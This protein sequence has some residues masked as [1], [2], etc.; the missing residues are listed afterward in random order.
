MRVPP[1]SQLVFDQVLS[2]GAVATS[3]FVPS[4]PK[5]NDWLGR[6]NDLRL[7]VVVSRA[8]I[9]GSVT[10]KVEETA[11]EEGPWWPRLTAINGA[12][13]SDT[14]E[15]VLVNSDREAVVFRPCL[16]YR[17][18]LVQI[19]GEAPVSARVRIWATGRNGYRQFN[20]LLLSERV[21]GTAPIYALHE[22][23]AWLA[24]ADAF[25]LMAAAD[26]MSGLAPTVSILLGE[27]PNGRVWS[28][29]PSAPVGPTS[30]V[31]QVQTVV[32]I[33]NGTMPWAGFARFGVILGGINPAATVRLWITGRDVRSG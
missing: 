27:G 1:G 15:T 30:P 18:L 31:S 8:T 19:A 2:N 11:D 29:I 14:S 10:V 12:A 16:G 3:E 6:A 25:A 32:G 26:E 21:V 17:R 9:L 24:G 4:D 20:R 5:F 22:A 33:L 7:F 13:F 28:E 23:C